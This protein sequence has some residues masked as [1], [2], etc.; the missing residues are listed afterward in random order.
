MIGQMDEADLITF[1]R[2]VLA[3][4]ADHPEVV[5]IVPTPNGYAAVRVDLLVHRVLVGAAKGQEVDHFD[6]D[7]LNNRRENLRLGTPSRNRSNQRSWKPVGHSR[8][9]G[10]CLHRSRKGDVTTRWQAN[11]RVDG[12]TLRL[13]YFKD[14]GDAARAFDAAALE[15][16]GTDYR[17]F[18]FPVAAAPVARHMTTQHPDFVEPTS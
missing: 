1:H 15:H 6:G 2:Q 7:P 9:R 14:E 12:R 5:R 17:W 3:Y 16:H 11:L 18:N 8:Y 13:G 4:I 10:V